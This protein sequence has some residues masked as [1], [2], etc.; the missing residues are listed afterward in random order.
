MIFG[1]KTEKNGGGNGGKTSK[2]NNHGALQS[3]TGDKPNGGK[4]GAKRGQRGQIL[5]RERVKSIY[6]YYL[7]CFALYW[8]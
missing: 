5:N 1:R 4:Q 6:F 7:N 2:L 3:K 8:N